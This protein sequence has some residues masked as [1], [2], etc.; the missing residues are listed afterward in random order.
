VLRF[1]FQQLKHRRGRA[2]ALGVGIF[3]AS[4]SFVVLTA[5]AKTSALHVK[6]SVRSNFR[7]AYDIL[8]RPPNS[9]TTLEQTERLVRPNYL[10]GVFGG[11]TLAQYQKIRA[12][13][14]VGVAAPIANLG[15]VLPLG[16]IPVSIS[17]LVTHDP[18]QLYRLHYTWVADNGMSHYAG[19]D[20]YVYYNR[21]DRFVL[22]QGFTPGGEL[23]P[24]RKSPLGVCL[25][26]ARSVPSANGPFK[27]S[28]Q[29]SLDC[30]SSRSPEIATENAAFAHGLPITDIGSAN[31]ATFPILVAAI[32]PAEEA[33]LLHLD[34]TV[35][36][37]RYLTQLDGPHVEQVG[38]A[39]HRLVPA[40]AS[41]RTFQSD[42]LRVTVEKLGGY[43]PS[44]LPQQLASK[45]GY[46]FAS[47]LGGKVV[48]TRSIDLQPIYNRL[49]G[50]QLFQAPGEINSF[51]YWS[52]SQVRYQQLGADRLRPLTVTGSKESW[53]SGFYFPSG[54]YWPAPPANRDVQFR[55]LQEHEKSNFSDPSGVQRGASLKIVGRYDP[56]QLPGFSPLSQVPLETYYPPLL[57]P[58]DNRTSSLLGGSPFLPSQNLG[59]YIQQ[60]PLILI[61]LAALRPFLNSHFYTGASPAAP[62]SAIR[63]RVNGVHGPD[64]VSMARIR[65]AALEIHD[66]TGLAVDITAGSSP[67]PVAIELPA[68]QYGRPT[69]NLREGWSKKGVSLAFLK[70]VDRKDIALFFLILA[71]CGVFVAN[72]A[73]AVV[74]ARRTEIGTLLTVGW[75]QRDIFLAVL[76]E[77][78][79]VGAIAGAVGAGAA[80]ITVYAFDLNASPVQMLLVWPLAIGVALV[81]GIVP[82]WLASRQVPLDAVRPPVVG[83]ER[84]G[85]ARSMRA[86]AW[87]NLWRLPVRTALGAFSL[88]AGV[89]SLTLLLGID[90]AFQGSLVGTLLG[91]AVSLR[92]SGYDFASVSVTIGLA[93]LAVSDIIYLN[94][95]QR[96]AELVTLRSVGWSDGQLLRLIALEGLGL[97]VLGCG[98][99]AL[100]G[101]AIG[102]LLGIPVVDVAL[103]GAVAAVGG[104]VVGLIASIIPA[105]R[106]AQLTPP[107]VLAAE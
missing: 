21:R 41:V 60:P 17:N 62:I 85:Q 48:Q 27:T 67:H 64:A 6:G 97:G 8:V 104:I 35:V 16:N 3:I 33:K 12:I 106:L 53:K 80:A 65:A 102:V 22:G 15:Y 73:S 18:V 98:T 29:A 56:T 1:L 75:R 89:A 54:G 79:A 46:A 9:A 72:G 101:V 77:L 63:V 34:K 83:R 13:K 42:R 61:S 51:A 23:I 28:N 84:S 44:N 91:S 19:S 47:A 55:A 52:V 4:S 5:T 100:A 57:Q 69:L 2:L 103:A 76:G 45:Q 50:G 70:A 107:T 88:F 49:L 40:I 92:V 93:A 30:F 14:S 37:G 26:F 10:G 7:T 95:R 66:R 78:A 82:S 87:V 25:G 24:G 11:I 39:G 71:I 68:G 105:S 94:L 31:T 74:R 99:G 36:A 86:L 90:S 43:D 81:A 58:N 20:G 96:A 32:D 59:G 38:S